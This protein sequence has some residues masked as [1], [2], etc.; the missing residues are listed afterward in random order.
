MLLPADKE[1]SFAHDKL[2]KNEM[3]EAKSSDWGTLK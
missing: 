2:G 1:K 3:K